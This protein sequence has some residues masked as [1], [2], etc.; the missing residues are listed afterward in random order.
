MPV[1]LKIHNFRYLCA[2]TFSSKKHLG[3]NEFC[4]ACGF[5]TPQLFNKYFAESYIKSLFVTRFSKK[6]YKLVKNSDFKIFLLTNHHREILLKKKFTEKNLFILPNFIS[7]SNTK[8]IQSKKQFLYAGR[9]SK[10]KGIEELI[11]SFLSLSLKNYFLKIIGTGPDLERLKFKYQDKNV[12]FTG[13]M[14]NQ[15]VQKEIQNSS[16]VVS[17]TKLY[18]GQ[19]TLLCEA[20][21]KSVPVIFPNS[22]GIAEFLPK[23]YSFLFEQ[24]NY[25]DL[26][27]LLKTIINSDLNKIGNENKIFIDN[28]INQEN[29]LEVFSKATS[30]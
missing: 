5:A 29:L 1:V 6:L 4:P 12:S 15:D 11:T 8:V 19:P 18:E 28:L 17:A 9:I 25:D 22:G 16:V 20:S 26:K 23:E 2:N 14:E 21:L 7:S 10:E 30:K 3:D 13:F 27:R 24:N